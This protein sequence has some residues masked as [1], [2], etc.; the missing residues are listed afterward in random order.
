MKSGMARMIHYEDYEPAPEVVAVRPN[1]YKDSWYFWGEADILS[2]MTEGFLRASNTRNIFTAEWEVG[3]EQ[4]ETTEWEGLATWDRYFNR[5]FTI[6][7]GANF[8]GETNEIEKTRGVL[9]L[10]Y[11]LPVNVES[12]AWVDTDGGMRFMFDKEFEL[13]PRLMLVGEAEY[14]THKTEWEESVGL[15]YLVHKN[16]SVTAR[17]HSDYDWGVGVQVRF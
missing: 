12:R 4:V 7:A 1:L 3:W 6:F 5:F 9:G 15:S 8:L 16:F 17:W 10:H 13:T 11:L 2:N 14:D